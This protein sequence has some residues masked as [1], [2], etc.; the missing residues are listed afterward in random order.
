MRDATAGTHSARDRIWGATRLWRSRKV[1]T[2]D[3]MAV[4]VKGREEVKRKAH[5]EAGVRRCRVANA[6]HLLHRGP[7][8]IRFFEPRVLLAVCTLHQIYESKMFQD[9]R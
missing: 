1:G 6:S 2:R 8:V 4:R 7:K 9:D 5:R 3:I